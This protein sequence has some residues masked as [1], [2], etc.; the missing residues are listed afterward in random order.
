MLT[1]SPSSGSRILMPALPWC[2]VFTWERRLSTRLKPRPHL[3]HRKGFSPGK[4][5]GKGAVG[6]GV[7]PGGGAGLW[8]VPTR[9]DDDVLGQVAHVD[10]GFVADGAL[11]GPDVVVVT[12]VVG[13][14]A[15]LDKPLGRKDTAVTT[16]HGTATPT[17]EVPL[18]AFPRGILTSSHTARTRRASPRCAGARGR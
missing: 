3:S 2:T 18:P 16:T 5:T 10:E 6:Q 11:V 15:G 14:L 9:V 17:P 1:S 8:E 4:G 7:R 12:D 13:Q